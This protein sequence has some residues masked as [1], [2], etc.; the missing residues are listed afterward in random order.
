MR[1]QTQEVLKKFLKEALQEAMRM[2]ALA[3]P[4]IVLYLIQVFET[5][6]DTGEF[7]INWT[8]L[9]AITVLALLRGTDRGLHESGISERGITRF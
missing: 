6:K 1:P 3:S 8:Y 2:Y 5:M 4:I 7:K 9:V